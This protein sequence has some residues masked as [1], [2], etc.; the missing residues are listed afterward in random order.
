MAEV[1]A[2]PQG[3][4]RLACKLAWKEQVQTGRGAGNLGQMAKPGKMDSVPGEEQRRKLCRWARTES[5]VKTMDSGGK[6]TQQEEC[7]PCLRSAQVPSLAN[8]RVP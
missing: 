5:A 8:H 1:Q 3:S 2:V 7:L 6:L 4:L